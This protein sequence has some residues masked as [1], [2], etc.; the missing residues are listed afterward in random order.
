[1]RLVD[2]QGNRGVSVEGPGEADRWVRDLLVKVWGENWA[3][4]SSG[5]LARTPL[6]TVYRTGQGLSGLWEKGKAE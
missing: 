3:S 1:M 6:A 5:K 2:S 4:E